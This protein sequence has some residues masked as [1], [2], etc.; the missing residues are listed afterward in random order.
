MVDSYQIRVEL[1]FSAGHRLLEHDGKCLYP[2]GHNYRVEIWLASQSL[3]RMGFVMDFTELKQR[4]N[5]WIEDNWDHAFLLNSNDQELLGALKGVQG[6]RLY[7]F[8]D[9]N[10]SAEVMARELY[11]RTKDLCGTEPSAVRVWES[12]TQ[13]AEYQSVV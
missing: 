3:T 12:P 7:I 13:Y 10:P 6:S 8:D 1:D 5:S 9:M 2:H 4:V 11:F